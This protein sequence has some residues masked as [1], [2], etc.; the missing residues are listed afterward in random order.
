MRA[1]FDRF[2]RRTLGVVA[3]ARCTRFLR[4]LREACMKGKPG[5]VEFWSRVKDEGR[6][7]SLISD[8][9]AGVRGGTSDATEP[10]AA[11]VRIQPSHC[12]FLLTLDF[13]RY[14]HSLLSSDC[15][16]RLTSADALFAGM[17]AA[18]DRECV[19]LC[20]RSRAGE[21]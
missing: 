8:K 19:T 6:A 10:E 17:Y 18:L 9:E 7:F 12:R 15:A 16:C 1:W 14:P 5:N 20:K 3:D 4:N 2:V 13:V 11:E 21:G